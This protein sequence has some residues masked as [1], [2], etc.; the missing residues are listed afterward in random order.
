VFCD[1]WL[2]YFGPPDVVIVDQGREFVAKEFKTLADASAFLLHVIDVRSPWQNGRTERQGDIYKKLVQRARWN[3]E[4]SNDRAWWIL[5]SE[6]VA[7]KNRLSNRSGYS[8]LQR[9]FGLSH[10]LPADLCSDDA[11]R[12]ESIDDLLDQDASVQ[13]AREIRD[14]SHRPR[15]RFPSGQKQRGHASKTSDSA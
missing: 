1:S 3:H 8:P 12:R 7:A 2:R 11:L 5:L 13:E 15:L 4:P 14:R 10:R 6:C 9:V